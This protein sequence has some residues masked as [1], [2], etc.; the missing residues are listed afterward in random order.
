M[1][2]SVFLAN[3]VAC[4]RRAKIAAQQLELHCSSEGNHTGS[5]KGGVLTRASIEDAPA[6]GQS[7]P[8]DKLLSNIP[9]HAEIAN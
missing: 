6:T 3:T 8:E 7:H 1:N 2:T 5:A 4:Y 9:T